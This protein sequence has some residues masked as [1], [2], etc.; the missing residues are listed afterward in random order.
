VLLRRQIY[1]L[2]FAASL[3]ERSLSAEDVHSEM[4]AE[5]SA[6]STALIQAAKDDNRPIAARLIVRNHDLNASEGDGFTALHWAAYNDDLRLVTLLLKSGAAVEPRTR[7]EGV[8]PL[9]LAAGNGSAEVIKA[10]LA[11]GAKVDTANENGTTALMQ[12]AAAGSPQ[13]LLVLLDH[14]ANVNAREKSFGQTALFF[15]AA[16]DRF[17]A[18]QLLETH[19]AD[20]SAKT[21]V[22]KFER[23][24]VGVDGEELPSGAKKDSALPGQKP[25][26]ATRVAGAKG[27]TPDAYGFTAEDRRSRV[28]GSLAMGGLTALHVAARDGQVHAV[29]A[30]LAAHADADAR[31]GTDKATPLLLALINGHYDTARLLLDHNADTTLTTTDGLSALYAVI[32]VQWAPHTWYPQPITAQENT[33]YLE[34]LDLLLK[35]NANPNA[36]LTRKLWFRVFANDET[37]V[38]VTGATPFWRAAMAGDLPTM[39]LLAA[40]GADTNVTSKSGDTALMVASG[41][42]WAAYWTSNAPSSRLDAV[43]FCLEHGAQINNADVKGYTAIHGAAFRG[44][45]ALI[46]YLLAQGADLSAKTKQG[47]TVA[48]SANGLFEHAVVHPETVALLERLGSHSSN[49]CRSNECLV[50]TKEEKQG[51][52]AKVVATQEH[53]PAPAVTGEKR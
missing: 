45:D 42:G 6:R 27:D 4:K 37:W 29:E 47:D 16:R 30:L 49:N 22:Q 24:S 11:A 39:A 23:V 5:S 8:T 40:H 17:E 19:G 46:S 9:I 7:L 21:S 41:I 15:A 53:A 51:S 34:L 43:K 52:V 50:P 32:D 2:I 38:D 13:A 10:L 18:I 25:A 26:G 12:A 31:T 35:R 3:L 14:G 20:T 28:Y 44:D 48:D 36:A 33:T 1:F